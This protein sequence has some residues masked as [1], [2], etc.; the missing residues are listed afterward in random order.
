[1]IRSMTGFGRVDFAVGEQRFQLEVRSVNHRHLDLTVRLPRTF[2]EHESTLRARLKDCFA[3]G[4]V[5][6]SLLVSSGGGGEAEPRV[7]EVAALHYVTAA[8]E[9]AERHGLDASLDVGR[10]LQLPGVVRL[11]EPELPAETLQA[12]LLDAVD[13]AAAAA[14]AMRDAEGAAIARD[15]EVRLEG[16]TEACRGVEARAGTVAEAARERLGKRAE[17]L[18]RETG[19]IDEARLHQEIVHA[20]DRMD[21]TEEVVRL[22][23]HVEQF[24]STLQGATPGEPVGRGLDFLLQEMLREANTIGSK[25]SDAPISQLVVELKTELERVREQIQNVE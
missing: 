8:R 23:S 11:T 15:L 16:I 1:V 10:L 13:G 12:A 7:D 2:I 24:G 17:Q 3:R 18:A 6:V 4:K 19:V 21:V 25:G 22:R 20:A 14:V 5:D 9:L